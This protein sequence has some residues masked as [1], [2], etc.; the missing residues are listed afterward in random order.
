MIREIAETQ[1]FCA[2]EG[3]GLD[4]WAFLLKYKLELHIKL[5]DEVLNKI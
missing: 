2:A 4:F 3:A 1:L 5:A